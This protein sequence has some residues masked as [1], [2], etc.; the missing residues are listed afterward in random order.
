M[1][2]LTSFA[3]LEVATYDLLAEIRTRIN[4]VRIDLNRKVYISNWSFAQNC[5]DPLLIGHLQLFLRKHDGYDHER[6]LAL[7]D[8][9]EKAVAD[10]KSMRCEICRRLP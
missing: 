3:S 9:C 5:V 1:S 2:K 7:L 4:G 6:M 10:V 8:R